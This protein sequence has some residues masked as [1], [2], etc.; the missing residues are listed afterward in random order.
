M[1]L[2]EIRKTLEDSLAQLNAE[3]VQILVG[4]VSVICIWLK[5]L[6]LSQNELVKSRLRNEEIESELVRYK[7][8]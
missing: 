2:S 3:H 8:L 4:C 6:D 1:Q 7:L 5:E